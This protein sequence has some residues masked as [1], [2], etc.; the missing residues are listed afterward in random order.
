MEGM[1][2]GHCQAHVEKALKAVPGVVS[3]TVELNPG[4]AT[5]TGEA[6]AAALVKAVTDEGYKAAVA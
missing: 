1:M 6:A 2:C 3:V 5:V 4:R